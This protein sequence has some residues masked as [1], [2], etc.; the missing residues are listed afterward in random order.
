MLK[1]KSDNGKFDIVL[2]EANLLHASGTEKAHKGRSKGVNSKALQ[3]RVSHPSGSKNQVTTVKH[4]KSNDK[5]SSS[6]KGHQRNET[7]GEISTERVTWVTEDASYL[8]K[9][10]LSKT[11][12]LNS[13]NHQSAT[14]EGFE[15]SI[16]AHRM[17]NSEKRED[18]VAKISGKETAK[19]QQGNL[20]E[21]NLQWK[22]ELDEQVALKLKLQEQKD[23][24]LKEREFEDYN[25]WGRPGGGAPIR[26]QSGKVVADFKEMTKKEL[27]G[28]SSQTSE[29]T[30]RI[31]TTGE[32]T[33]EN[34]VNTDIPL[35]MRSSFAAGAPGIVQFETDQSKAEEK[36]K[37]VQD[38]EQQIKEKKARKAQEK[39]LQL[40]VE[41]SHEA[42]VGSLFV[43][44]SGKVGGSPVSVE[45]SAPS[46]ATVVAVAGRSVNVHARG[47]GLQNLAL[48][49]QDEL[50][51]KRLKTLEHQLAIKE[52]VEE[53]RRLKQEEKERA[54]RE[55][56]DKE[57]LL[58][59]ERQRLQ[60]QHEEELK[61]QRKKEEEAQRRA[62]STEKSV[63]KAHE[64]VKHQK[65]TKWIKYLESAGHDVSGLTSRMRKTT[66]LSNKS[67]HGMVHGDGSPP[68]QIEVR[69]RDVPLQSSSQ[70][71]RVIATSTSPRIVHGSYEFPNE[72][73]RSQGA[74]EEALKDLSLRESLESEWTSS[75][76]AYEVTSPSLHRGEMQS[77]KKTRLHS[78]KGQRKKQVPKKAKNKLEST[79]NTTGQVDHPATLEDAFMLPYRRTSS[80]T[81]YLKQESPSSNQNITED[82]SDSTR[83]KSLPVQTTAHKKQPKNS[84]K[85]AASTKKDT[86]RA[87]VSKTTKADPKSNSKPTDLPKGRDEKRKVMQDDGKTIL[88]PGKISPEILGTARQE[89]ILKQLAALRQGLMMKERELQF[90]ALS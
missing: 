18:L 21:K 41:P 49:D 56:A 22:R 72:N 19:L 35:A 73:D 34:D 15:K 69:L 65:T 43:A 23:M 7:M 60:M 33:S 74:L 10:Q 86:T 11:L 64:S 24:S 67:D 2:D 63:L 79:K 44:K 57:R 17:S 68:R 55:E 83:G 42:P 39:L 61:R 40:S 1:V 77:I 6:M 87:K 3:P 5:R 84:T 32:T 14:V 81:F 89:M 59:Q 36:K 82:I 75:S 62:E 51:K 46:T 9:T 45:T 26:T 54:I 53:K 85:T 58:A 20:S 27:M 16:E 71:E 29:V 47:Q 13:E 28:R 78:E 52:Q 8:T 76:Q 31:M 50:E 25:P 88:L 37:W 90:G 70:P 80:A 4:A 30:P 66:P 38:L 48:V 12:S